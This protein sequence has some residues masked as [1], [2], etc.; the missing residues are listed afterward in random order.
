MLAHNTRPDF[1]VS[2]LVGVIDRTL[3]SMCSRPS[4]YMAI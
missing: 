2:F 3:T 4:N 1:L